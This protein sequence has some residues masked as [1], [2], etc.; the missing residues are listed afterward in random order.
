MTIAQRTA[1]ESTRT[2]I[3]DYDGSIIL[4]S[5][6]IMIC[7]LIA[8]YLGFIAGAAPGEFAAMTVYP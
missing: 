6:A 1:I 2:E 4:G 7:F 8:I 5:V 3:R